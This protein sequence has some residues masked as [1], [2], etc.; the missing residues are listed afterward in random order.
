METPKEG[1]VKRKWSTL[2]HYGPQY[3]KLG[4]A[5]SVPYQSLLR[6]QRHLSY[7]SRPLLLFFFVFWPFSRQETGIYSCLALKFAPPP[8]SVDAT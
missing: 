3:P 8:I 4:S 2:V 5:N 1:G 7:L 6:F